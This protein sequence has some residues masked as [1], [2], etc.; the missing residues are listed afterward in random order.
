MSCL[1]NTKAFEK[2]NLVKQIPNTS[3]LTK[4]TKGQ[5]IIYAILNM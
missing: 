5:N 4:S 2:I 3:K 1:H